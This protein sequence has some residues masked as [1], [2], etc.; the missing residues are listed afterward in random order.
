MKQASW[1]DWKDI[2]DLYHVRVSCDCYRVADQ[3][4]NTGDHSINVGTLLIITMYHLS[5]LGYV[6]NI[7]KDM[8]LYKEFFK[9]H[10]CLFILPKL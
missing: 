4:P 2:W 5:N 6:Q 3:P 10:N 1:A 7:I 8:C 9:D